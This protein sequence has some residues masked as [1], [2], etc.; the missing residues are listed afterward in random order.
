M[1][2]KEDDVGSLFSIP[3]TCF[4]FNH[5]FDQQ[6]SRARTLPV[7]KSAGS[8]VNPEHD[9]HYKNHGVANL[10]VYMSAATHSGKK[11]ESLE[12]KLKL[13]AANF[14]TKLRAI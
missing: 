12:L 14:V 3:Q 4:F 8:D 13:E 10:L 9:I 11:A 1:P 7:D 5:C 6:K 2:T